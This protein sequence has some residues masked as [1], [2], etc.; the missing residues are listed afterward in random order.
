MA[1]PGRPS[2]RFLGLLLLIVLV[3]LGIRVAYVWTVTRHDEALGDQYYYS[4]LANTLAEGRGFAEPDIED[5][6]VPSADHP[7]LTSIVAAPASWIVGTDGDAATRHRRLTA[8]RLV[9][10]GVGAA[11]VAAIGFAARRYGTDPRAAERIGLLAASLAAVHPGLWIND[12]LIMSESVGALTIALLTWA[13]LACLSQPTAW[14]MGALGMAAGL[15]GLARAE[16]LLLVP[17]L[18]VPVAFTRR[19]DPDRR[20]LYPRTRWLSAAAAGTLLVL[21]PWVVPNL[22]RFNQ[23]VTMST[24]D[25]LT[26]LGTNCDRAYQ[27]ESR[28]LWLLQCIDSVDT[29]GD[30]VDDWAEYSA[31]TPALGEDQDESDQSAA[32][33]SEAIDYARHHLHDLPAVAAHRVGRVWGVV[34]VRQQTDFYNVNE[35]RHRNV[36][37]AAAIAFPILAITAV[38]GMFVLRRRRL[39]V[40]PVGVHFASTTIVAA[41]FYGLIRFRVGAEVA[42]VVGAAVALDALWARVRGRSPGAADAEDDQPASPDGGNDTA[43]PNASGDAPGGDD[44]GSAGDRVD[45]GTLAP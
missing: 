13:A 42:V 25:G 27:G 16:A 23:L 38:A 33:R 34:D 22:F 19:G 31:G 18:V 26:L 41:L 30:G 44:D 45:A 5:R 1:E 14:R 39:P 2:R 21:G 36:S 9:M 12:G 28:G 3:G 6:A 8:Q 32:Y 10:A 37:R 24:N 17:L 20:P 4:A 15:A 43:T 35:G 40:W 7:P 11:T 29:D